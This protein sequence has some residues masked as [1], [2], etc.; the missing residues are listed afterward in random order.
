M[1]SSETMN[2]SASGAYDVEKR[3]HEPDDT[4]R[5]IPTAGSMYITPEMFEKLYLS[6]QNR[7][8]GDVRQ[9]FG[10]PTPM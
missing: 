3:P 7:V 5:S 1:A 9:M 6:P 4:L 10:N 8:K 2:H